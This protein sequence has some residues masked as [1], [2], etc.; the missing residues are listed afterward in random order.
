MVRNMMPACQHDAS[1][2]HTPPGWREEPVP[3]ARRPKFVWVQRD[4]TG[5]VLRSFERRVDLEEALEG[6]ASF[7]GSAWLGQ[8]VGG[9]WEIRARA[10]PNALERVL[11][12]LVATHALSALPPEKT[13]KAH[14]TYCV[15]NVYVAGEPFPRP[16]AAGRG[17]RGGGDGGDAAD[18]GEEAAEEEEEQLADIERERLRNIERNQEIL[19]QLGLA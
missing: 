17:G 5:A 7:R 14:V 3:G 1:Q 2:F 12:G 6:E 10:L 9:V 4:A 16:P 8:F 13:G 11:S 19:R 18:E 15:A